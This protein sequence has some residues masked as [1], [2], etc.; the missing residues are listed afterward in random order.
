MKERR[1]KDKKSL[2][3]DESF[4]KNKLDC[5]STTFILPPSSLILHPF[6]SG[7]GI[8]LAME[9]GADKN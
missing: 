4:H 7:S 9:R 8:V 3:K 1:Q 6:F 5:F 2:D